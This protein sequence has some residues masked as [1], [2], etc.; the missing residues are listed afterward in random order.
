M[1]IGVSLRKGNTT[2]KDAIDSVLGTMTE[3]DFNDLMAQAIAVQP[4]AN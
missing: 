2:L 3:S 4:L 1:N